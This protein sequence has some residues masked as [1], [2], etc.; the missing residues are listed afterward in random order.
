MP[1]KGPQGKATLYVV[2]EKSAGRWSYEVLEL[3]VEA[4]GERID[5]SGS[6]E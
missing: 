2:A 5:L 1:L 3:E 6:M 4:T